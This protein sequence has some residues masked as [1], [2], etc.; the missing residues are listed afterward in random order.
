M[1]GIRNR[2]VE[3][4]QAYNQYEPV[5]DRSFGKAYPSRTDTIASMAKTGA[6]RLLIVTVVLGL[7]Y[8]LYTFISSRFS[9]DSQPPSS[10]DIGR[11]ERDVPQEKFNQKELDSICPTKTM[12]NDA[13]DVS[14]STCVIPKD[15]PPVI[16]DPSQAKT[17]TEILASYERAT[18]V[19]NQATQ[20]MILSILLGNLMTNMGSSGDFIT[21]IKEQKNEQAV[22]QLIDF[23]IDKYGRHISSYPSMPSFAHDREQVKAKINAIMRQ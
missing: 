1:E 7:L 15:N 17:N 8:A 22:S 10:P 21:L 13:P 11:E 5:F 20:F 14:E 9:S 23:I 3:Q 2:P 19:S 6:K 4:T 12:F 18:S 16:Y